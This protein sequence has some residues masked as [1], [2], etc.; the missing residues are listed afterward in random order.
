MTQ[1][2]KCFMKLKVNVMKNLVSAETKKD[3]ISQ[4]Y[5]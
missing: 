5:T 1:V 2:F 4:I 3:E